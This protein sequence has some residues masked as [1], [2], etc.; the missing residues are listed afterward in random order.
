MTADGLYL[1]PLSDSHR[2]TDLAPDW[3][4]PAGLSVSSV[5]SQLTIWGKLKRSASILR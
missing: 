5:D 1:K 2:G 3:F 4:G